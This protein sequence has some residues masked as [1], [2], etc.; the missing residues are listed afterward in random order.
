MAGQYESMFEKLIYERLEPLLGFKLKQ[1][2]LL[3]RKFGFVFKRGYYW[4][5]VSGLFRN[6]LITDEL[7]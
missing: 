4:L 7:T 6:S 1:I 3:G 2:L 5:T